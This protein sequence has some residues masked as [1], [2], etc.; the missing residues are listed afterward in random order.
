MSLVIRLSRIGR[1]GEAKYRVV[2]KEKRS[3]RDGKAIDVIGSYERMVGKESKNIDA[4][5]LAK[6]KSVGAQMSPAVE[7]LLSAK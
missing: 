1:K 2:V 3:N 7:K 4:E 5:K 6:W